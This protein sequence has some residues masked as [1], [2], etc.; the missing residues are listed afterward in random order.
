MS[1]TNYLEMNRLGWDRRVQAHFESRF[2]DVDGFVAGKT[3][4]REI[5]LAELNDVAGKRLLHLQ[6]HFGMDTLS[7]VRQ[8]AVCTGVD[9]SPVAIG[10]A[11][12]LARRCRLDA[13]FVCSD[14]QTFRYPRSEQFDI[15]FVDPP[16][17]ADVR[18]ILE[19]LVPALRTGARVYLERERGDP[20]PELPSLSWVRRAAA[21]GVEFGLAELADQAQS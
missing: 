20:W 10:K 3:S 5:E 7:W 11:R 16:Y 4:L 14:V 9:I 8:G 17:A 12:E 2:Y 1:H 13:E 21:G 18:P 15:V 6:C 19:A